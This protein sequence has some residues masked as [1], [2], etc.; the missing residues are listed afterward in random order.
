MCE[1]CVTAAEVPERGVV[2]RRGLLAGFGAG[3]GLSVVGLVAG[4][5]AASAASAKNG[6]WANPALGHFPSGGHYG[7]PAAVPPTPGRTS[8]TRPARASTRRRPGP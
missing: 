7:A 2:S 5:P 3:L 8:P 4:A 6:S 1:S